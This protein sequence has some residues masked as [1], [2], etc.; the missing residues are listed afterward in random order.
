[1]VLIPC[2]RQLK[3]IGQ[4]G[5]NPHF[6]FIPRAYDLPDHNII[7]WLVVF[8]RIF[9][10]SQMMYLLSP[11]QR[12]DLTMQKF[13][14]CKTLQQVISV[15]VNRK[16]CYPCVES[17]VASPYHIINNRYTYTWPLMKKSW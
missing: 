16:P 3:I 2:N 5:I 7:A 8:M 1:M 4:I 11:D 14:C 12:W 13:H 15:T 10:Q 9:W 17:Y 6:L